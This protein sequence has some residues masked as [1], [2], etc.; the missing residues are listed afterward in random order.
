MKFLQNYNGNIL[1]NK[2]ESTSAQIQPKNGGKIGQDK[3]KVGL[4]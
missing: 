1:K 2:Y 3:M 4:L